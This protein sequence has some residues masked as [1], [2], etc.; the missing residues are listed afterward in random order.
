MPEN[1]SSRSSDTGSD[2]TGCDTDEGCKYSGGRKG[3]KRPSSENLR[4]LKE[5]SDNLEYSTKPPKIPTPPTSLQ[6]VQSPHPVTHPIDN[7]DLINNALQVLN[8]DEIAVVNALLELLKNTSSE[9]GTSSGP[10]QQPNALDTNV[11]TPQT[12]TSGVSGSSCSSGASS[13]LLQHFSVS[14]SLIQPSTLRCRK[15]HLQHSSADDLTGSDTS[16]P[17]TGSGGTNPSGVNSTLK[18][19]SPQPSTSHQHSSADDLTGSD[20]STPQTGSG[21]TNPSGVNS[22]LDADSPQPSTSHTDNPSSPDPSVSSPEPSTSIL[23]NLFIME[24]PKFNK[25]EIRHRFNFS[26]AYTLDSFAEVL[27]IYT[28]PFN[29]Y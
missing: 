7:F 25:I 17:Q 27:I 10:A 29:K 11:K 24:C 19:D 16:S 8:S 3:R 6:I 15:V 28:R 21:V 26:E 1:S 12:F 23:S 4:L 5:M 9:A 14:D 13:S 20:T 2:S 18:A 22:S